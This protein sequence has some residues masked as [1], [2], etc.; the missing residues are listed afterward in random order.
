M[1]VLMY[2]EYR[3]PLPEGGMSTFAFTL[4]PAEVD[5]L[6]KKLDGSARIDA[7]GVVTLLGYPTGP[8]HP[9]MWSKVG[10]RIALSGSD[11]DA[12]LADDLRGTIAHY[13]ALFL[14]DL[15]PVVSELRAA[16]QG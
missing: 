4:E 16:P 7:H 9:V 2:A 8:S 5:G 14:A 11:Q 1:S 6:T 12:P 3:V 10:D 13:L 15:A